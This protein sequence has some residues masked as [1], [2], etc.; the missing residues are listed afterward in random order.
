MIRKKH[1]KKRGRQYKGGGGELR[2]A[3]GGQGCIRNTQKEP[4]RDCVGV[5]DGLEELV[6]ALGCQYV[7][8]LLMAVHWDFVA[9]DYMT[10]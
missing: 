6:F 8:V 10:S 9:T 3:A 4:V 5:A 7:S 1:K 2:G